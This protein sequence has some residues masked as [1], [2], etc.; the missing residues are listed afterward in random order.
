MSFL[1]NFSRDVRYGLVQMVLINY[2]LKRMFILILLLAPLLSHGQEDDTLL[3]PF[4]EVNNS[5]IK[6]SM[7]LRQPKFENEKIIIGNYYIKIFNV[8]NDKKNFKPE[9]IRLLFENEKRDWAVNLYLYWI[10]D[11][12]AF[13]LLH[14][15][16]DQWRKY[17]KEEDLK[18]WLEFYSNDEK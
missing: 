9:E 5:N 17:Q 16:E 13:N 14:V 6:Y 2:R 10:N 4:D 12:L 11:K 18:Y 8:Q 1:N 3:L 7:M 15:E